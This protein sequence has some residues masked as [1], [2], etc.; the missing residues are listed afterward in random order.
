MGTTLLTG[1]V[2]VIALGFAFTNGFH[3]AANSV[4]ATIATRA[5]TTRGA[6]VMA[7]VLNLLG[8]LLGTQVALT[9]GSGIV[10]V[11]DVVG[12]RGLLIAGSA[13]VGALAWNLATWWRGLPSSSS[14]ALIGALAG[15]GLAGG[16]HV[17]WER[18]PQIVV[19]PMVL[20]PLIGLLAAWS[21]IRL[22]RTWL[23]AQPYGRTM[24]RFCL[25]EAVSSA[26]MALGHGLQDAQKT[27][28]V[29]L[30]TLL[31]GGAT[32]LAAGTWMGG[33]RIIRTLGG[34]IAP[35]DASQGF[36]AQSVSAV[37]L[38][39]AAF[40]GGAPVSTT[41]TAA[42]AITGAGLAPRSR[43]VGWGT[44]GRIAFAWFVTLPAAGAVAAL[45]SWGLTALV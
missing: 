24:T 38:Y 11:D 42:A 37:V 22:L 20:S 43:Q 3:D 15:A 30:L 6:L 31:A 29:I 40:V 28:G 32:E 16:A 19:A 8:A 26:M 39:V 10:D 25:T 17:H 12:V 18:L 9:V 35:I 7:A 2:V 34:D 33:L 41:C 23:A 4:A 45:L 14:Q 5:V 21:L 1:T 13:L 44:V 36:V 27:M